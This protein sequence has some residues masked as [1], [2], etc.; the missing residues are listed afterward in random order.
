MWWGLGRGVHWAGSVREKGKGQHES[1]GNI[2]LLRENRPVS[3]LLW[4]S[5]ERKGGIIL[6]DTGDKTE[7]RIQEG[8]APAECC[9][10]ESLFCFQR[11]RGIWTANAPGNQ[12]I[13]PPYFLLPK[14][15]SSKGVNMSLVAATVEIPS[16]ISPP[17]PHQP[18]LRS[19]GFLNK[20]L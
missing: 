3:P 14:A 15:S 20:H 11:T 16:A 8:P 17:Q 18:L 4:G 1:S 19:C 10:P 2:S 5:P 7:R 6:M 13:P 12:G 9:A